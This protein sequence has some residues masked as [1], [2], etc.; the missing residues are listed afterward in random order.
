MP[1]K[2]FRHIFLQKLSPK[3]YFSCLIPLG[4]FLLV[5]FLVIFRN[6]I[7]YLGLFSK[8]FELLAINYPVYLA[9]CASHHLSSNTTHFKKH[10]YSREQWNVCLRTRCPNLKLQFLMIEKR[11]KNIIH[12]CIFK[13]SKKDLGILYGFWA[14]KR[15]LSGPEGRSKKFCPKAEGRGAEFF[16]PSQGA[17]QNS[18]PCPKSVQNRILLYFPIQDYLSLFM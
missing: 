5:L 7:V 18:F 15:I 16:R 12:A 10:H 17:G 2:I 8:S 9:Y 3:H 1:E 6:H 13:N 11:K 14:R 4:S